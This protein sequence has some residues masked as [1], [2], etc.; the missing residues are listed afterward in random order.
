M[1]RFSVTLALVTGWPSRATRASKR[2]RPTFGS[3]TSV[4]WNGPAACVLPISAAPAACPMRG[5]AIIRL[6]PRTKPVTT[7]DIVFIVLNP[8]VLGVVPIVL[9]KIGVTGSASARAG[10]GHVRL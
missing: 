10:S 7:W 2:V 8:S 3:P 1:L 6:A 4:T 5:E 9:W